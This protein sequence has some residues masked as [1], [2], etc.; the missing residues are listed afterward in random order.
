MVL[1]I[2]LALCELLSPRVL[3][4]ACSDPGCR[5]DASPALLL[6]PPGKGLAQG[7]TSLMGPV[8]TTALQGQ[9]P[10]GNGARSH[11]GAARR[12]ARRRRCCANKSWAFGERSQPLALGG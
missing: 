4:W 11:L 7:T 3:P 2:T 12:R 9:A 5:E 6:L 1:I 10:V 8:W